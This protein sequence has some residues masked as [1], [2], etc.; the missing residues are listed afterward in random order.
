MSRAHLLRIA[1]PVLLAIFIAAHAL[2]IYVFFLDRRIAR[3]LK[4]HSWREPTIIT[5]VSNGKRR[6]VARVYG[7]DWRATPPV[8]ID[9]LPDHV[10]NAF[11]AAEDVRFR[12]HIGIDPIQQ[13]QR[14][15]S[16]LRLVGRSKQE[17][18]FV[19]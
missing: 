8:L 7:V 4:T 19:D 17:R 5:G 6:E 13:I 18:Q 10:I 16:S 15:R 12:S 11:I 9:D 14:P 3:E 2:S 1:L